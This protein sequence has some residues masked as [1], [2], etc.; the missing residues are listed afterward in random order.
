MRPKKERRRGRTYS[1]GDCSLVVQIFAQTTNNLKLFFNSQTVNSGL[2]DISNTGLIHGNETVIVHVGEESHD[3]LA[4]HTV[5]NT[6][7]ARDRLAKV[8][9]FERALKSGSEESTERCDQGGE[10]CENQDVE[11]NGLD[12]ERGSNS[13]PVGNSIW[14]RHKGRVRRAFQSGQNVRTEVINRANK[15]LVAHEDVGHEVTETNSAEPG[16][17]E[18]FNC[19]LW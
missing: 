5:R 18:P 4:V 7:V 12:V 11:L 2:N 17:Q 15:V 16:A 1:F 9:N 6:T 3:E 19:L 14:L 8:L 13:G 10:G